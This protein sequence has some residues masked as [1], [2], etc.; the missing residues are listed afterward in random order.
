MKTTQ[1]KQIR[2]R[3]EALRKAIENESISYGEIAELQS[4]RDCIDSNDAVLLEWAGV[5]EKEYNLEE[6]HAE[7]KK[8]I[9]E[10]EKQTDRA[11]SILL[12]VAKNGGFN[13][14]MVSP[15]ALAD[16]LEA[17]SHE[18]MSINI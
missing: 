3:L 8:Q 2:A 4:L 6:D 16:E 15:M 9:K 13:N 10:W 17:M 5:P 11:V 14:D 18:M 7:I 12:E 1:Q